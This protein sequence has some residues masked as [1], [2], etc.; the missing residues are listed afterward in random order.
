MDQLAVVPILALGA[1]LLWQARRLRDAAQARARTRGAFLDAVR[2]LLSDTLLRTEPDGFPRLA[3]TYHG[4]RFDLR[5]VPDTL[6]PLL[7]ARRV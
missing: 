6:K 4:A 3:G 5:V 2:P 1:L 7:V